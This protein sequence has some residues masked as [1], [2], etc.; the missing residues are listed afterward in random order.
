MVGAD[1][2]IVLPASILFGAAFLVLCDVVARTIMAPI[3]LP[4][5]VVTAIIG[6]PFFMWLL[7]RRT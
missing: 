2:R 4:V 3:E 6:G 7:V 1:H 5:G